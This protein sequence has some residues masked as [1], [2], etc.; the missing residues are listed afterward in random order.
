MR[1]VLRAGKLISFDP[2]QGLGFIAPCGGEEHVP[3]QTEAVRFVDVVAE[4]QLV[5]YAIER[6][7]AAVRAVEVRPA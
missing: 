4:G 5:I 1:S 7:D 3:F 2:A 6:A